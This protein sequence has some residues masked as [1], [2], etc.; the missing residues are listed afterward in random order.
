M[1][2]RITINYHPEEKA[3]KNHAFPGK[4]DLYKY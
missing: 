2:D 4:D 1:C 3:K